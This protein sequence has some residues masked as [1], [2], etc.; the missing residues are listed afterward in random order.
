MHCFMV[1]AFQDP[2]LCSST[3]R[4]WGSLSLGQQF[5]GPFWISLDIMGEREFVKKQW[6]PAGEWCWKIVKLDLITGRWF[7]VCFAATKIIITVHKDNQ[8]VYEMSWLFLPILGVVVLCRPTT[9]YRRSCTLYS[10]LVP[11]SFMCRHPHLK[12]MIDI[13]GPL[14]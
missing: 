8:K 14:S 12:A 9:I 4:K 1:Q 13:G 2:P 7:L 11:L 6:I 10:S 5:L 3:Y